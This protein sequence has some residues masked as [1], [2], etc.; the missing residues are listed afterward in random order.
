MWRVGLLGLLLAGCSQASEPV[1]PPPSSKAEA[2]PGDPTAPIVP[3]ADAPAGVIFG[4]PVSSSNYYLAKYISMKYPTPREERAT[5]AQREQYIWEN[6]ILSFE[7]YRRGIHATDQQFEDRIN[8]VLRSQGQ[9]FTRAGDPAAY[10]AWVTGQVNETVAGFENHMRYLLE[11]DL[12]KD[13]VRLAAPVTVTDEEIRQEFLNE[14]HHVGGEMVVFPTRD[15]AAA[16]YATVA[17]PGQW[18]AMKSSGREVRPVGLMTLEAYIDLWGVPRE[19]IYAFHALEPGAVGE[20]MPFGDEWAVVRLGEKRIADESQ[21]PAKA[22]SYRQQ[23]VM[24]Q[25]Y[26]A[27]EEWIERLKA[28]AKLTVLLPAS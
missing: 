4:Y 9:P 6:L 10:A 7:A 13:Q 1:S 2:G 22:E 25:Q 20:P 19:Q 23:L 16:F 21:L 8:L 14:G 17:A 28:D 24:K 18:D 27:L 26:R 15:E 12:L 3:A 5:P 11:I